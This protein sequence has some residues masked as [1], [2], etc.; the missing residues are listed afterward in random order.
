[1]SAMQSLTE[2]VLKEFTGILPDSVLK[3]P[4]LLPL[5][6]FANVN[7]ERSSGL[8]KVTQPVIDMLESACNSSRVQASWLSGSFDQAFPDCFGAPPY[9]QL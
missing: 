6:G 8:P 2:Q 1:M 5:E 7:Y 9:G 4:I 3:L